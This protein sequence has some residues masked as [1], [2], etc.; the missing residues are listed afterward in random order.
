M[1]TALHERQPTQPHPPPT[2][3][4]PP[5]SL[6]ELLYHNG[7]GQHVNPSTTSRH[8]NCGIVQSLSS[9]CIR[10]TSSPLP[11]GYT[12]HGNLLSALAPPT[13]VTTPPTLPS[14]NQ[15]LHTRYN[16]QFHR[17]QS[18]VPPNYNDMSSS[19]SFPNTPEAS[20]RHVM[21]T[22]YYNTG[23]T[24]GTNLTPSQGTRGE[25][26]SLTPPPLYYP[27]K[28]RPTLVSSHSLTHNGITRQQEVGGYFAADNDSVDSFEL[29]LSS[30]S[31]A[32]LSPPT[33]YQMGRAGSFGSSA[34]G[35][36]HE[37]SNSFP[38][39]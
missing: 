28:P 20:R 21:T 24:Q 27:P 16:Q 13:T 10:R 3:P 8:G 30:S 2:Q 1:E 34:A 32:S 5:P 22:P 25:Y 15:H 11:P 18:P 17:Q 29:L 23:G 38:Y 31:P 26:K 37:H 36:T 33:R 35:Y 14:Y 6:D 4:H 9:H 19:N 7:G 39:K 12:T